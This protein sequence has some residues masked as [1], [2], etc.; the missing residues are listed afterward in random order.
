MTI[1]RMLVS[2]L[3]LAPLSPAPPDAGGQRELT[4]N[5]DDAGRAVEWRI[6]LATP[7]AIADAADLVEGEAVAFAGYADRPRFPDDPMARRLTADRAL[8]VRDRRSR[9]ASEVAALPTILE[10]LDELERTIESIAMRAIEVGIAGE[11][12]RIALILNAPAAVG[13]LALAWRL[14]ETGVTPQAAH[15]ALLIE[16]LQSLSPAVDVGA[17]LTH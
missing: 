11:R 14:A 12:L 15:E 8:A 10:R 17:Q 13:R 3:V 16:K 9:P 6:W 5:V 1:A 2:G 4:L 7:E